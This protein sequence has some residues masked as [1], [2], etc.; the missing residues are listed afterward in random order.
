MNR[1][2]PFPLGCSRPG[3][4]K[5]LPP[6]SGGRHKRNNLAMAAHALLRDAIE[7]DSG[8]CGGQGNHAPHEPLSQ[9]GDVR[10]LRVDLSQQP[11]DPGLNSLLEQIERGGAANPVEFTSAQDLVKALSGCTV[12][13]AR[14][15]AALGL[16]THRLQTAACVRKNGWLYLRS[17]GQVS[18]QWIAKKT[19]VR[20]DVAPGH[21]DSGS[22]GD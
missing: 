10:N 6:A 5:P 8:N 9:I 19:L 1:V 7:P 21:V 13:V 15:F 14:L 16:G 12:G 11:P 18:I 3:V 20:K 2:P 4:R 22:L 17:G